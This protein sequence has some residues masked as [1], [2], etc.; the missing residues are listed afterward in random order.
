MP[1]CPQCNE[2]Q[3]LGNVLLLTNS[4]TKK[5]HNC[6]TEYKLSKG[7]S[8]LFFLAGFGPVILETKLKILGDGA[9]SWIFGILWLS[10]GFVLYV[11]YLP[12]EREY[13]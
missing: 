1:K 11:K 4:E 13:D 6:G 9:A 2:K 10:I 8:A 12:L 3:K 7:K 5:C